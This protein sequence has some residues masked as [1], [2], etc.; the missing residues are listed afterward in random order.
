MWLEIWPDDY[1]DN[2]VY[3]NLL[4]GLVPGS[5]AMQLITRADRT[6]QASS[7]RLFVTEV[8]KP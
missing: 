8:E 3:D 6:A 7:Y 2:Q 4:A 1:Y 5:P